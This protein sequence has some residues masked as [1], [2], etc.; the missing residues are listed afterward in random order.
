ML[1]PQPGQSRLRFITA[2][3]AGCDELLIN[4]RRGLP[5]RIVFKQARG[6]EP[7]PVVPDKLTLRPVG[8]LFLL[9]NFE[10][11]AERILTVAQFF[12]ADSFLKRAWFR[13]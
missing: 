9:D 1:E 4:H 3:A 2:G 11:V 7:G 6:V 8:S 13:Q 10:N 12:E 5:L